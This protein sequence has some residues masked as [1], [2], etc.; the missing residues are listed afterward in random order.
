MTDALARTQDERTAIAPI[1]VMDRLLA[2]A[3]TLPEIKTAHDKIAAIGTYLKAQHASLEEQNA[4][5]IR[6]LVACRRIGAMLREMP[7]QGPGEYKRFQPGTVSPTLSDIGIAKTASHRWQAGR[8]AE[9]DA[10]ARAG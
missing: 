6:R 5:A 7:M 1:A 10:D 9:G 4:A 8:D 2:E 3:E